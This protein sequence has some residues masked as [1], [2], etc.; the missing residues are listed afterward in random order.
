MRQFSR[1]NLMQINTSHHITSHR[2]ISTIM[3]KI[4][5]IHLM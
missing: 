4:Q 1:T 3:A 5:K 2:F